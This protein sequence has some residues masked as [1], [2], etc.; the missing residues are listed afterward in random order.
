MIF[1]SFS[2][3]CENFPL[4]SVP[5][6]NSVWFCARND[7]SKLE[8]DVASGAAATHS[9]ISTWT[10]AEASGQS[11]CAWR[12]GRLGDAIDRSSEIPWCALALA[13]TAVAHA[14]K[15]GVVFRLRRR[16]SAVPRCLNCS[17]A[18]RSSASHRPTLFAKRLESSWPRDFLFREHF[19]VSRGDA[20][21]PSE[22]HPTS[23]GLPCGCG[24]RIIKDD[25][26]YERDREG[27][28]HHVEPTDAV[29]CW[30]HS[31]LTTSMSLRNKVGRGCK[32]DVVDV[33]LLVLRTAALQ[34]R[35]RQIP[36]AHRKPLISDRGETNISGIGRLELCSRLDSGFRVWSVL[37]CDWCLGR[38]SPPNWSSI[39]SA[40]LSRMA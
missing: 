30:V 31:S 9:P 32:F 3:S 17:D 10:E 29:A 37:V 8:L 1:F 6:S 21:S 40:I 28:T 16:R 4:L 11:S 34:F 39:T 25:N 13:L 35:A 12:P 38:L 26:R 18:S 19:G 5:G 20:R 27:A 7:G 23:P 33:W 14:A 24:V 15:C 2:C 36:P 22:F